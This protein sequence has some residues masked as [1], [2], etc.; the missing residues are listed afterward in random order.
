M[1]ARRTLTTATLLCA[2]LALALFVTMRPAAAFEIEPVTGQSGITSWLVSEDAVPIVALEVLFH[3]GS[4]LDPEGKAGLADMT[5]NLMTEGAGDL[6]SQAFAARLRD[7]N[8]SLSVSA[9]RDTIQIQMR[10]LSQNVEEAFELVRMAL[11][12]PRFD[13][14]AIARVRAQSLAGLAR[15][16]EDPDTV[17]YRTFFADVFAGH[18]YASSP[19]G[20]P[21]SIAAITADDLR[22]YAA[23]AFARD[24]ISVAVVGDISADALGLLIDKTFSALP[25]TTQRNDPASVAPLTPGITLVERNNPQT[26]IVF[27]MDGMTRDDPDFIPAFVMNYVLGGGSFVSRMFKEVREERGLVYSVYTSLY[28]LSHGGLLLGYLASGNETAAQALDVARAQIAAVASDG[29]TAEEL[30]TAKTFLTGSYA[31]RFDTSSSIAGQ[32]AAI[33]FEDLG[34]DYVER[35]NALV[36]AVTLDD[37]TRAAARLLNPDALRIVAV[38]APQ[39]L[40]ATAEQPSAN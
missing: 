26:V 23:Q 34:I 22:A 17:A 33:Q 24:N 31:L 10:T 29:I 28:P 36:E 37:I 8:V 11:L 1:T 12:E 32:L 5:A 19:S 7:L 27:G 15:D 13:D 25:E 39:G 2:A 4:H 30:D 3:A 16:A 35:R 38:G 9:G 20:T 40:T 6:D 14:T 18:P 21:D